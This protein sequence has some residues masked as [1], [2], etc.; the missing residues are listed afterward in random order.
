MEDLSRRWGNSSLTGKEKAGYVLPKTQRK[1]KFTIVAKFR[2]PRA[3]NMDV[4]GRTFEQVWRCSDGF[5]IRNMSDHKALFVFDD[6]RDV[7][8]ILANQP[9]SFDKH[10]VQVKRHDKDIP[11][12]F[13]TFEMTMFWVQVHDISIKYMTTE[14]AEYICNIISE[15]VRSIGSETEEGSSLSGLELSSIFLYLYA[16]DES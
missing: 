11:L 1:Y 8:Q 3:L 15:E 5:K 9:W 14:V 7:T 12:R 2:T 13:V 6:E 4:V 16:E 10:L